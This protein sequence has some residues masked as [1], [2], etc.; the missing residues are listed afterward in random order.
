MSSSEPI[1]SGEGTS[2]GQRAA[3][4]ALIGIAGF[5]FF[6]AAVVSLHFLMPQYDPRT[7]YVSEYAVGPYGYL[8][9]AA[10]FAWGMGSMALALG[11]RGALRPS[12]AS[13]AGFVLL[14]IA[15]VG[16]FVA[17]IFT[18]DL[19]GDPVTTR[20]TI[21]GLASVVLFLSIIPAIFLLSIGF[22]RDPRW[23]TFGSLSLGLGFV[24]LGTFFLFGGPGGIVEIGT[25]QRIFI[26]ALFVWLLVAAVWLRRVAAHPQVVVAGAH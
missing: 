16:V 23:Q 1:P 17:G 25:G 20:G 12:R 9:T 6:I 7:R 24:V 14:W 10:F 15:T 5:A 2:Q 3:S 11:I 8:M 4:L 26:G 22:R 13:Q 18:A 21:H 19:T